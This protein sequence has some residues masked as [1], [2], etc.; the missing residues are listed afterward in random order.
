M[1]IM[2]KESQEKGMRKNLHIANHLILP[3]MVTFPC[4]I[5]LYIYLHFGGHA[6][7][8]PIFLYFH[9]NNISSASIIPVNEITVNIV[10]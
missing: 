8:L 6:S 1:R 2:V 10:R 5:N 9:N 7:N 3:R 4:T